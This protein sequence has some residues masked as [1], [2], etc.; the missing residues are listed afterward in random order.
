MEKLKP[1]YIAEWE[2]DDSA[3]LNAVGSENIDCGELEKCW[4][5][6]VVKQLLREQWT[7]SAGLRRVNHGCPCTLEGSD[8]G[9]PALGN[10]GLE[11]S[12]GL[13]CVV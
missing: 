2:W 10:S 13:R 9:E 8:C 7:E 11:K 4:V 6:I 1:H 3:F 12:A 5:Q